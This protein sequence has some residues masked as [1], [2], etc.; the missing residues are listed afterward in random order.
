MYKLI[1]MVAL[2][3]CILVVPARAD[4]CRSAEGGVVQCDAAPASWTNCG[5]FQ[6]APIYCYPSGGGNSHSSRH[7]NTTAI[8]VSLGVGLAVVAVA[9]Y[10]F[11]KSPSENNPG[12]VQLATF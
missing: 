1:P 3:S 8:L 7:D 4:W 10:F 6:G 9:W 11:K 2:F 12:Q 5:E